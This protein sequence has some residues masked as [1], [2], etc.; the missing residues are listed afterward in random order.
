MSIAE[1]LRGCH[2]C[3]GRYVPYGSTESEAQRDKFI[4]FYRAT[5]PADLTGKSPQKGVQM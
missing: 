2:L 3:L 5:L 1:G 4:L